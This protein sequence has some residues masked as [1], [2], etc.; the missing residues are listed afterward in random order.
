MKVG[1][2]VFNGVEADFSFSE[3]PFEL[4]TGK[5]A[6]AESLA[7]GKTPPS[8]EVTSEFDQAALLRESGRR[9]RCLGGR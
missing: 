7:E 8:V 3:L 6:E 9:P 1:L 2:E 5:A 4:V